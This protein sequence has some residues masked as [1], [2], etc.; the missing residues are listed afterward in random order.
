MSGLAAAVSYVLS[1]VFPDRHFE[2]IVGPGQVVLVG[3]Q[4]G[5]PD[6]PADDV[7]RE[8][9]RQ[10]VLP[11][12]FYGACDPTNTFETSRHFKP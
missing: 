1:A 12:A 4:R 8:R 11:A 5:I 10:F 9:R 2:V 7:N 6:P 3:D